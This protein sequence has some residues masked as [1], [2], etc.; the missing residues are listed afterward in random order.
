MNKN[1]FMCDFKIRTAWKMSCTFLLQ[2]DEVIRYIIIIV[3][4]KSYN[5][6][7]S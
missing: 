7:H 4:M 3:H 6:T 2:L 5:N 1:C